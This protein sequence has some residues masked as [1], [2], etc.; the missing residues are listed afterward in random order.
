MRH[1]LLGYLL[2]AL[3]ADERVAI[4]QQLKIDPQLREQL[5]VYQAR[6]GLLGM[7]DQERDPPG[8]LAE[9]TVNAVNPDDRAA[10]AAPVFR[11]DLVMDRAG[12]ASSGWTFFDAVVV[13]MVMLLCVLLFFPA[14]LSS[15][16]LAHRNVCENNLRQLH[17]A[18]SL[19]SAM[20]IDRRFPYIATNGNQAF[21][22]M[23]GP[24]LIE[25]QL[26]ED[27][28]VFVCPSSPL[29]RNRASWYVPTP[30]EID[31]AK[32]YV[33]RQLQRQAFGSYGYSLGV[34]DRGKYLPPRNEN[35]P[36]FALIADAPSLHLPGRR[37]VN[38][39]MRG[40]NVLLED[41]HI[42][43]LRDMPGP[44]YPDHPF[45]SRRGLVEPGRDSYD[46]VIGSSFERP[47]ARGVQS[48]ALQAVRSD[49][50]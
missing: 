1:D 12:E 18:L 15:R 5:R 10:P 4:E 24:T 22:G 7:S 46:A 16:S 49:Q 45:L 32:G 42:Q 29:S 26:I 11:P 38:H 21:V 44:E 19:Y 41:G 14:V 33:L 28:A 40:Q 20:T 48:A 43:F 37:S 31:R 6:L 34:I 36:Y 30:A 39:G 47:F 27:A 25:L 17:Q 13:S 3:D 23:V 35:R 9:R 8:G 2:G 50:P